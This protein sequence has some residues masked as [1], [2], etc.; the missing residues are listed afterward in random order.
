MR[1][2]QTYTIA[3]VLF[4]ILLTACSNKNGEDSSA[5]HRST[6]D[7]GESASIN[8]EVNKKSTSES[9]SKQNDNQISKADKKKKN[10]SQSAANPDTERMVIYNADM[11]ITVQKL[12]QAQKNIQSQI[13]KTDGY[14][15]KSSV[16]NTEDSNKQK[17]ITARIPQSQFNNFLDKLKKIADQV[18]QRNVNGRDVTKQYVN[19]ESRL[20]AK[21]DVKKRLNTFLKQAKDTENL[22]DIS[23]KLGDIQED[24]EKIKGQMNY[25]KNHSA[26]STVTITIIEE[27]IEVGGVKQQNDLNTWEKTKQA[28]VHSTNVI[29]T[30]FSGVVIFLMGYSPILIP[31]II[32]AAVIYVIYRRRKGKSNE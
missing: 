19:L 23:N 30:F 28:F 24:I 13:N 32:I 12:Q 18:K 9:S 2:K 25:L 10:A 27:N 11:T 3:L 22:L 26:L 20:K 17:R 1:R 14:I 5:D 7:T 31:L 6:N 8:N 16:S 4:F 15:V 29:I 21:K